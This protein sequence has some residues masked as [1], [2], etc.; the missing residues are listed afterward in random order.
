MRY[1][2]FI[3]YIKN[4]IFLNVI[5]G[6]FYQY[7]PCFQ[8]KNRKNMQYDNNLREKNNK[9][10]CFSK[11]LYPKGT[12]GKKGVVLYS[13]HVTVSGSKLSIRCQKQTPYGANRS[14]S[15]IGNTLFLYK[16]TSRTQSRWDFDGRFGKSGN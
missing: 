4:C 9:K 15:G 11:S 7:L 1:L 14:L 5:V 12:S 8:N 3:W 13:G 6:T 16:S 2:L 10:N